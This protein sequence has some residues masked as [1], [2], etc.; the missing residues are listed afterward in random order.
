MKAVTEE[1]L[2]QDWEVVWM[3][4]Q[5]L[6]NTYEVEMEASARMDNIIERFKSTLSEDQAQ[7]FKMLM[8]LRDE[9]NVAVRVAVEDHYFRL[10]CLAAYGTLDQIRALINKNP[11]EEAKRI[12]GI[13][14]EYLQLV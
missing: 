12:A 14:D 4:I 1:R 2:S 6:G 3:M 11:V 9:T 5:D 8:D 10:G 13:F 7:T